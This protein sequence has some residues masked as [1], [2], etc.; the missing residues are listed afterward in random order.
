MCIYGNANDEKK[1]KKT[2]INT[3]V[4]ELIQTANYKC[5]SCK[6]VGLERKSGKERRQNYENAGKLDSFQK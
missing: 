6:I 1:K 2:K 5:G 4:F 3:R